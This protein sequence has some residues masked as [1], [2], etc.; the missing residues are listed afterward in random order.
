MVGQGTEHNWHPGRRLS[1]QSLELALCRNVVDL[2]I[3]S[4]LTSLNALVLQV[5]P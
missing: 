3:V 1:L 2:D 5:H 4:Q